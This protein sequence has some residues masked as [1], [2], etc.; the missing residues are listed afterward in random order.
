MLK[1]DKTGFNMQVVK[2]LPRDKWLKLH[3]HIEGAEE[4]YAK[5]GKQPKEAKKEEK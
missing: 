1:V 4:W 2:D 3:D 5:H